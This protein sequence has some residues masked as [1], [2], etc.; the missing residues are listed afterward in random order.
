V[1]C[2]GAFAVL[3]ASSVDSHGNCTGAVDN[4]S[5]AVAADLR[6]SIASRAVEVVRI[7]DIEGGL[8][9][10]HALQLRRQENVFGAGSSV[11]T[12]ESFHHFPS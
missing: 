8:E 4:Q 10:D 5:P 9:M 1:E 7:I 3:Q 11:G 12:V 2:D 6:F